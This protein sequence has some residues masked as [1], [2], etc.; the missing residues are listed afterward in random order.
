MSLKTKV[1]LSRFREE[2]DQFLLAIHVS[3][4]SVASFIELRGA[5]K[6][7][8]SKDFYQR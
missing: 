8:Y 2:I 4:I 1:P 7:R 6:Y 5:Q 3:I